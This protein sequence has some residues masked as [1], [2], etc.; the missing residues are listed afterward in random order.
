MAILQVDHSKVKLGKSPARHDSRTLC[1]AKYLRALPP[2][3][4]SADFTSKVPVASWGMLGNDTVG[5]CTCAG[6]L[7]MDEAWTANASTII[8]PTTA[9]AISAYSAIT[10]YVPGEPSTDQGANELDVLNYWRATGIGGRKILAYA[11]VDV[12]NEVEVKTAT[13]LFGGL[14]LGLEMPTAWQGQT[15][16]DAPG[17][18][19]KLLHFGGDWTPGSWGGHCVPIEAYSGDNYTVVTWGSLVTLT[20]AGLAEYCDEAYALISSDWITRNGTAPSGF[21]LAQLQADLAELT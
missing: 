20:Q 18:L 19:A 21:D 15:T 5:D 8:V 7:H 14:Y 1:L 11:S 4:A 16:W 12:S 3:P 13:Y 2:P 10:G 9:E 6:A 17:F